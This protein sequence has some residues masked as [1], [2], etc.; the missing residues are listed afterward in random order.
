MAALGDPRSVS[1]V[2][3][4]AFLEALAKYAPSVR[5]AFID[6][7]QDITDNAVLEKVVEALERG[8]TETAWRTLGVQQSVFSRIASA[9]T[10]TFEQHAMSIM[11]ALPERTR[12]GIKMRFNIRDPIA[13]EWL[14]NQ[15]STLIT[16]VTEDMRSVA[17]TTMTDGLAQGRNPRKTALD[18]IG[19]YDASTGH[20]EGGVLGL[21]VQQEQWSRAAR[22]R[23]VALDEGYFTLELRDKRFDSVVRTAIRDGK[24]LPDATI[25]RMIDR[26]RANALRHRGEQIAR[27]ETLASLNHSEYESVRQALAQ[28]DLPMEATTKRWKTARDDRVRHSH[29]ALHNVSVPF[30]EPFVTPYGSRMMHPGDATLGAQGRDIIG[31]RCRVAYETNWFYGVK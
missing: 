9:L 31:C 5:Q 12:E 13:E 20:R 29:E 3:E 25:E 8:D 19:R 21:T 16:N 27:T 14:R 17:Q 22:A 1:V 4:A 30:D 10:A 6:A 24:P 26:Y 18:L 28:S 11:A 15:S 23:L 7:V 2:N